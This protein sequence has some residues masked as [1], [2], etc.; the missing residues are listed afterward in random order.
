MEVTPMRPA[1]RIAV[2]AA[3]TALIPACN[4]IH[5]KETT[6]QYVDDTTLAARATA[7]LVKDKQVSASDFHLDVYMGNV[8]ISGTARNSAEAARAVE[9]LHNVRG[10]KSVKNATRVASSDE[11]SKER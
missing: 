2:A 3:A 7:A 11:E 6:G 8:T 9:D 4:L 10:V 1:L 5:G